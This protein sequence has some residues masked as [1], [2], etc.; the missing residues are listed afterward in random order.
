VH[1]RDAVRQ[2]LGQRRDRGGVV[3]A[4]GHHDLL[5]G[6]VATV[7]PDLE[8]AG[9][10]APQAGHGRPLDDRR[11]ER[12]GVLLEVAHHLGAGHEPVGV[13][14]AV[15]EARQLALPVRS[16]QAERAPA[17]LPPLV[18]HLLPLQH[19]VVDAALAQQIAHRQ[20]GLTAADNGDRPTP[21]HAV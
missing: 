20:A 4:G 16:D 19:Q 3:G 5:R 15:T 21:A 1:L 18:P 6:E 14:P 10:D 11:P 2:P 7:G 9:G 13:R 12:R 17:P 8:H